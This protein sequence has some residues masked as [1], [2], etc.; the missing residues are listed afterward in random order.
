MSSHEQSPAGSQRSAN[1][2]TPPP[3]YSVHAPN[4]QSP[5]SS[6]HSMMDAIP[7]HYLY[8]E[9]SLF[10]SS[11]GPQFAPPSSF[12]PTPLVPSQPTLGLLPYYDPHSAY[13]IEAATSRARRR[14]IGAA[15]WAIGLIVCLFVLGA[16]RGLRAI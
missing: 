16:L 11:T 15:L 8:R 14:F 13:F 9:Q 4:Q 12:G 3:E 2:D 7:G 5:P 6:Q 10:S 1:P